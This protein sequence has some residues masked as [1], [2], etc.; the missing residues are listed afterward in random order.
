MGKWS[1]PHEATLGKSKLDF[2][3]KNIKGIP[4]GWQ[5]KMIIMIGHE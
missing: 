1:L 3:F 5:R 4:F 2:I